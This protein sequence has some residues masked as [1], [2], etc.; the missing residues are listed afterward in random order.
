[1][2]LGILTGKGT[3]DD[4]VA[5][6][7]DGGTTVDTAGVPGLS[8]T[9][10]GQGGEEDVALVRIPTNRGTADGDSAVTALI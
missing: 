3:V 7:V 1:M 6:L 9:A 8:V 4:L 5:T 10:L 2:L